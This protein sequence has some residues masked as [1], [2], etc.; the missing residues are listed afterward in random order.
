MKAE[1]QLLST[2]VIGTLYAMAAFTVWGV[3]PI[4]WKLLQ[5]VPSSEILMHRIFWSFIFVSG[6]LLVR[7]QTP[8]VRRTLAVGPHRRALVLSAVLISS[9]WFVYIWAVN[10]NH[11]V[12]ASMGYYINPLFSV[13]LGVL[14]LGERLTFWQIIAFAL[15][16]TGVL[17]MTVHYGQVPW[18]AL[19][20]TFTFG[21]YGL[22][23]KMVPVTSLIGLGLETCLVAPFCFAYLAFKTYQGV[24]AFGTI[25]WPVTLLLIGSGAVT[26]L[27]LLWF[28]QAAKN[29]PLSKVGF[30]Q[31]IAPT[32]SLL[33]GVFMFHEPF[34]RVHLL[35]F[36][37]IWCALTIYSFSHTALLRNLR[38]R[39]AG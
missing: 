38:L 35:S 23:K 29:I 31:Y 12:E 37:C 14:V 15:A 36:G 21:L 6:I 3:L 7:R 22:S 19:A 13:L 28:A 24:G 8:A 1:Q 27:P 34:T 20:L 4:Y 10:S 30:L 17:I 16:A 25:S 18:I 39:K 33:L 5:Q 9:N 26:S 2:N 32:I 11:V